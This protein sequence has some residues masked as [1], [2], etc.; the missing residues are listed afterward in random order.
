[1]YFKKDQHPNDGVLYKV[2]HFNNVVS[3]L[4]LKI[5]ETIENGVFTLLL[6]VFK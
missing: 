6:Q 2:L 4:F 5:L 1:M 3:L